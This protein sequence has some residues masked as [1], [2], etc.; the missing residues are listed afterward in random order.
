L[1][2]DNPAGQTPAHH[3]KHREYDRPNGESD[4]SFACRLS[5]LLTVNIN[6]KIAIIQL[7]WK[8][9]LRHK[10][11]LAEPDQ[12]WRLEGVP[13]KNGANEGRAMT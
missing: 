10:E 2:A 11:K 12:Q 9:R 4:L 5:Y 6:H 13:A 3:H 1:G 7:V 8:V